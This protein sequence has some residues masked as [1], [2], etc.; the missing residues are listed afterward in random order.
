VLEV[1]TRGPF[2]GPRAYDSSGLP[3]AFD[4]SGKLEALRAQK[5]PS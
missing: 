1:E 3:L 2:K 4:V 5:A